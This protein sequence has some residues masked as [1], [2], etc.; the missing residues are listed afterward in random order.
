M[1]QFRHRGMVCKREPLATLLPLFMV[2]TRTEKWEAKERPVSKKC[3]VGLSRTSDAVKIAFGM[4]P[5]GG[6]RLGLFHLP[7]SNVDVLTI[8]DAS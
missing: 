1:P 8:A 4:I 2:G 7:D 6:W 3:V 5:K